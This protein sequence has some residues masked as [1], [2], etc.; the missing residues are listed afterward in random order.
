MKSLFRSLLIPF[1]IL[2]V[3]AQTYAQSRGTIQGKVITSDRK[4]AENVS[5]RL[6]GTRYGTI[7]NNN[8]EYTLRA[9]AGSYNL[10]VS[11]VGVQSTE[12]AV[13]V[14]SSKTLR[15]PALTINTGNAQLK[16]VNVNGGSTR[17]TPK[18]SN[19]AAKIPLS[20]LENAQSYTTIT[21]ELLKEQ[22]V[23]SVDDALRNSSGIQKLWDA[24]GRG[25]DGGSYF[26][27]RGFVVQSSLRNGVAGLVTN[28]VEVVNTDKVEV[29]K[30]PSGT[31]YGSALP[32]FG[33]LV[34]RVT[35][36]PYE[37]FGGEVSQSVGG[38]N[39]GFGKFSLSRTAIDVNTPVTANENVLFRLNA[40]YN[41][42]NS[43]Q[44]YGQASNIALAPSLSIKASEKLSFLLESE[45]F[46]GRSSSMR[47]FF[48]FYDS[49]KA[50][51]I[52]KVSDLN[53][54]YNQA[55]INE[56][57]TQRSRSVN[58]FAQ[59]NYKI[60][61]KITSQ[62]IFSSSNSFSNGASPYFYL[63]TD[64]TALGAS[65]ATPA[66]RNYILRYDQST[67]NSKNNVMQVQENIN[68]DFNIGQLRNRFVVGL[69]YQHVNS[70]Q[71]FYGNFY[72]VAPISSSTFDYGSANRAVQ[73]QLTPKQFSNADVYPYI[74][75]RNTYSAYI[76]DVIN[77]TEQLLASAGIRVDHF[78]NGNNYQYD[79]TLSTGSKEYS[80]TAFS[81]KFGLVYQPIKEQFS[82]FANYQNGF[83]NPGYYTNAAGQSVRAEIQNANQLEGGVKM[84]LFNGKLNGTVSYYR[85]KLTNVLRN[86]IGT[87]APN[88]SVQ[89]GTQLSKGFEADVVANPFAGL[90]IVAG[91]SYNDSKFSKANADV[92]GL[93]PNTAGSPYL[94]NFYISYRLPK[95]AI[96]GLGAGLGGNYASENKVINSVSQGTFSLPSYTVLNANLFYDVAKYRISLNANNVGNKHYYTGYT[97]INP[98]N[99][100]QFVLSAAY[101]F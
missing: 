47:P 31:L 74:Y 17:F 82:L 100:R 55:Y 79:G 70:N 87:T 64:A 94:A 80:Q 23:F 28:T 69:D 76:S 5:V 50:L 45:M 57:I 1:F 12:S 37:A 18:V 36:K 68:G 96:K 97:T 67:L 25:G 13:T 24:T 48:F 8:G 93:R 7:T 3:F 85:I 56:D 44:N 91:F 22:Q 101:K 49:P 4:P 84:A 89:D 20:P 72:G 81:P 92:Q 73:Y 29:I 41:F 33:G 19:D 88:A 30:G 58:Y 2:A 65:A 10:V 95:T 35:K 61:D 32:S 38:Y 54:D 6:Q 78:R 15:L 52:S 43:F 98:Q 9:P 66:G 51:G 26:T 14:T 90:N 34:N 71:V 46:F 21:N 75:K 77:I 27:L 16:E 62:T 99:L 86:A 63:V 11:Q 53:I 39:Y 60:S 83:T 59:A 40:A 42:N